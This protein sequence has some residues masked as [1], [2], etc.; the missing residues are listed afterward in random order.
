MRLSLFIA[1]LFNSTKTKLNQVISFLTTRMGI[2]DFRNSLIVK[3]VLFLFGVICLLSTDLFGW[4]MDTFLILIGAAA[5]ML[6]VAEGKEEVEEDEET[7]SVELPEDIKQGILK[8]LNESLFTNIDTVPTT[9]QS[10]VKSEDIGFIE[11]DDSE[12]DD[13]WYSK[14]W[15]WGDKLD[16]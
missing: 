14:S 10:E 16:K 3:I 6:A 15:L 5:I 8:A 12:Y 7:I 2:Q 4:S 9:E 11:L 13:T 1:E